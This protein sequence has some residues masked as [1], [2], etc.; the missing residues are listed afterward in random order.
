MN[1]QRGSA[2]LIVASTIGLAAI[3]SALSAD[4][5]RVATARTRAQTAADAAALAAAQE[6]I[7]PSLMTPAEV[8][9][10]YA[11][12][13][14]AEVTDCRCRL[15]SDEVFVAVQT[16]V[17]LPFL[18]GE[19]Q[20]GAQARA[21]VEPLEMLGLNPEFA[22]R[23]RCLFAIVPGLSIVSGFRT[24]AEQA[25]LYEEKPDLAAPPGHSMHELGLAADLGFPSDSARDL[26]H[27]SAGSCLLVFPMSY[28]P[29][30]I[31]PIGAMHA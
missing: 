27:S 16:E 3:L 12:R 22:S 9:Q 15:G 23:L 4:L 13:H 8:A 29:W 6:L 20:V 25:A 5:A 17:S 7:A 24:H 31:E 19:R 30:H 18:G 11:D 14:S 2:S 10:E 26:A 21:V 28:E 1:R